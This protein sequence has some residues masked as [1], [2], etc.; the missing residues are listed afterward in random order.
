[1]QVLHSGDLIAE[2]KIKV[3]R[4]GKGVDALSK[5]SSDEAQSQVKPVLAASSAKL[6]LSAVREY[7]MLSALP[8]A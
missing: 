6:L 5:P 7:A 3:G 8:H 4:A 1:L 2:G